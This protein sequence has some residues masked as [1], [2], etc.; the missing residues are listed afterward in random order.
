ME[1]SACTIHTFCPFWRVRMS[2]CAC[3]PVREGGN[4]EV[5]GGGGVPSGGGERIG[6]VSGQA[7]S[8]LFRTA[9][10]SWKV[11]CANLRGNSAGK[12][13]HLPSPPAGGRFGEQGVFSYHASRAE[14]PAGAQHQQ[15]CASLDFTLFAQLRDNRQQKRCQ[16]TLQRC[17]NTPG[18]RGGRAARKHR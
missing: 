12:K 2:F 5:L 4:Q 9:D 3:E 13:S 1:E 6:T 18:S 11:L 8:S 16:F 17:M 15:H 7:G 10:I 14:R